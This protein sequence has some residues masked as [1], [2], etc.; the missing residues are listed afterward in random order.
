MELQKTPLPGLIKF[1]ALKE[2]A[3][4]L[5]AE[6]AQV[7]VTDDVTEAIGSQI[8]VKAKNFKNVIEAKRV[9]L[10]A[11]SKKEGEDIDAAAKYIVEELKKAIDS[12]NKGLLAFKEKKENERLAEFHR[13][14]QLKVD[15]G[16]QKK[17]IMQMI[18]HA[19]TGDQ[20]KSIFV[21]YIKTFPTAEVWQDIATDAAAVLVEL[22]NY[23]SARKQMLANPEK[24]A[25]LQQ[26]QDEIAEAIE[27]TTAS[28]GEVMLADNAANKTTGLRTNFKQEVVNIAEVPRHFL[29]VDEGKLK[30][31]HKLEREEGRLL[32]DT[33][34]YGIRFYPEK[35]L[36]GR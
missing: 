30:A 12:A 6:C 15:L 10:K 31:F 2:S 18:N 21:N 25:E 26:V 34:I 22:K 33:T 24:A 36:S 23:G 7:K 8:I 16:N 5:A 11:P 29:I 19:T 3:D 32:E 28:A 27:E 9:E 4:G 1:Q 20:L 13:I 17:N 35:S 14:N